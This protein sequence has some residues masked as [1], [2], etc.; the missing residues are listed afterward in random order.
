MTTINAQLLRF[1]HFPFFSLR[2]EYFEVIPNN[3]ESIGKERETGE[4]EEGAP[5]VAPAIIVS[6]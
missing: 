4:R 1:R 2:V 3:F 6:N 5:A